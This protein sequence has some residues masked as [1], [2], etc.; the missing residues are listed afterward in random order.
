MNTSNIHIYIHTNTLPQE[1]KEA[2]WEVYQPYYTYEKETFLSRFHTNNHYALYYADGELVGFTGL[3]INEVRVEKHNHLLI[4]FGQTVI[5]KS[6][7][8]K[9]L[10]R[11][12]G[13]K[14]IRRYWKQILFSK[15]WFWADALSYKAYLVFAKNLKE[16]YPTRQHATPAAV[17]ELIDFIGDLHYGET[18]CKQTGTVLKTVKYVA[19]PS[20]MI[21]RQDREDADV[22]FYA[23][24]N[25]QSSLGHG[26]ITMGPISLANVVRLVKRAIRKR[27]FR[28]TKATAWAS[29]KT[30][31]GQLTPST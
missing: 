2:M 27:F 21:R 10:I 11:M 31:L 6:F 23:R 8:G 16:Y 9:G 29:R 13:L 19:D 15:A 14:L 1:T 28:K 3:R 18:Y 30:E 22:D 12:T 5:S 24:A 7:R 25:P 26:L 20:S 17:R 4:Y